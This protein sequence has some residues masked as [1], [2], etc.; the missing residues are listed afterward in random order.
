MQPLNETE[1]G[2]L[3]RFPTR[4]ELA[5]TADLLNKVATAPPGI[6]A[7]KPNW[8]NVLSKTRV[9]LYKRHRHSSL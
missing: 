8:A 7:A 3:V 2:A 1:V 4:R 9:G 5:T 6:A